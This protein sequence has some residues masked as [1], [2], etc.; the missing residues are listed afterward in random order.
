[1]RSAATA[2]GL[3]ID[4]TFRGTER[5]AQ[6]R[7]RGRRPDADWAFRSADHH[8]Q[9]VHEFIFGADGLSTS[10]FWRARPACRSPFRFMQG[11]TEKSAKLDFHCTETVALSDAVGDNGT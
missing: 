1:V 11:K 4:F 3:L 10:W 6:I 8:P 9:G 2:T 5:L 7:D